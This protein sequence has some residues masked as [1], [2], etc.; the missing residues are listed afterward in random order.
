LFHLGWDQK[1]ADT[2]LAEFELPPGRR[3]KHLSRGMRSALGIVLG[4][5]AQAPVTLFDEPYA[6]LDATVR[7]LFYDRILAEYTEHPRTFMV[8]THLI[9]EAADLLERV[10]VIDRGH[11]V[12]DAAADELRGSATAI[13]GPAPAVAEFIT[14]R[15]TWERRTVG[16][17]A[18][19][20]I[21]DMLDATDQ[22]RARQLHLS[23]APLSLQEI[24]VRATYG[25]TGGRDALEEVR[26]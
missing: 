5:A 14:G 7:R 12:L 4:L 20:T 21:A 10:L 2:L 18:T 24:V 13:S 15:T 19:A 9:D 6:G 1:L 11:I 16:T 3:I 23:V 25:Q 17:L 8:S 26:P 22:A